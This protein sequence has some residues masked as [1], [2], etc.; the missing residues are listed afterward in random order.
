MDNGTLR[1]NQQLM[2]VSSP[3]KV[4]GCPRL[5]VGIVPTASGELP[6]L[7]RALPTSIGEQLMRIRASPTSVGG[8]LTRVGAVL[9][10]IGNR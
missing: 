7:N 10:S 5:S 1:K 8:L 6:M 2:V 9:V 4:F 3:P